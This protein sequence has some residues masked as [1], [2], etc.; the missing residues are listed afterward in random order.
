MVEGSQLHSAD[1][2][3]IKRVI[4]TSLDDALERVRTGRLASASLFAYVREPTTF[5]NGHLFQRVEEVHRFN[6]AGEL[7]VRFCT[8]VMVTI[9][10]GEI[11]N[12]QPVGVGHRIYPWL[13][14]PR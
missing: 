2:A 11:G 7:L 8:G 10:D 13:P 3:D 12:S 5:V 1:S 6:P 9:Q 4:T 14:P